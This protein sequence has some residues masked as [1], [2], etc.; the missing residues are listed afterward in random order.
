MCEIEKV[1]IDIFSE[2]DNPGN[3]LEIS[4]FHE[5]FH[6]VVPHS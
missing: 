4:N 5:H 3:G 6:K 2:E 1:I